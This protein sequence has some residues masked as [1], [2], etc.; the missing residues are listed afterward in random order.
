MEGDISDEQQ[1][2]AESIP[3]KTAELITQEVK[4]DIAGEEDEQT[5][6][7]Y[8][9]LMKDQRE[10]EF[11]LPTWYKEKVDPQRVIYMGSGHDVI[12]KHVFGEDK[13][14][15]L[16]MEDYLIDEETG[17][18]DKRYFPELGSGIKAIGDATEASFKNGSFDAV[19]IQDM[20]PDN[21]D[22]FGEE[23]TR[24]LKDGGGV[25]LSKTM[26][27][28]DKFEG[29]VSFLKESDNYKQ[30]VVPQ[31]L[32]SRGMSDNEFFVFRKEKAE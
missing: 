22:S 21:I 26:L 13:I 15:H 8:D 19:F 30:V 18:K 5:R 11:L 32:Q 24:L 25:I 10:S 4:K 29:Q 3:A 28:S 6:E 20:T 23:I 17:V 9:E 12:P 27:T 16:S 2:A 14:V 1:L 31:N 7:F